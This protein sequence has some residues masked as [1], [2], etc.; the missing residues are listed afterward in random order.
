MAVLG[1]THKE[2]WVAFIFAH[3]NL[4]REIDKRAAA[5][6]TVPLDIYDILL[7]LEESPNRMLRMS[8]LAD[9]SMLTRSG[10]TRLV[11]R[12]E[13]EGLVARKACPSDRRAVHAMLTEK[14]LK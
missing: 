11:D 4:T 8:E 6:G 13:K 10:L 7:V 5:A 14:G 1:R 12:L 9:Q 2:A 3:A